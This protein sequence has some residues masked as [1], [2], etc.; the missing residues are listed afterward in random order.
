[1]S[2]KLPSLIILLCLHLTLFAQAPKS[3]AGK[4]ITAGLTA[5]VPIRVTG[6]HDIGAISLKLCFDE[7]LIA[8]TGISGSAFPNFQAGSDSGCVFIGWITDGISPAPTLP[9]GD[10]LLFV[11]FVFINPGTSPLVWTDNGI[12]CEFAGFPLIAPLSDTPTDQ[13]Y[14]DGWVSTLKVVFDRNYNTGALI[15]IPQDGQAPYTLSWT[16]PG[17]FSAGNTSTVY[18]PGNGYYT[19]HV[20]DALGAEGSFSYYYGPVHNTDTKLDY[21]SIQEAIDAPETLDGQH[22]LADPGVYLEMVSVY[23]SLRIQGSGAAQSRVS[24]ATNSIFTITADNVI[25]EDFEIS[26]SGIVSPGNNGLR[27]VQVQGAIIRNNLIKTN[28]CGIKLENADLNEITQNEILLN[29]H[30]GILL[31]GSSENEILDNVISGHSFAGIHLFANISSSALNTINDN[32]IHGNLNGILLEDDE[33]GAQL[34]GNVAGNQISNNLIYN[35][36]QSGLKMLQT[37]PLEIAQAELN[38]WGDATGPY[39]SEW[40][41]CGKGNAAIGN[42]DFDPWWWEDSR[43]HFN[44]LARPDYQSPEAIQSLPGVP[45]ILRDTLLFTDY[46]D[47]HPDILMDIALR[48]HSPA[49]P[50]GMRLIRLRSQLGN[51]PISDQALDYELSSDSVH[52]LSAITGIAAEALQTYANASLTLEFWMEGADNEMIEMPFLLETLTYSDPDSCISPA[53]NTD[54]ILLSFREMIAFDA[55]DRA[56]LLCDTFRMAFEEAFPVIR[57]SGAEILSDARIQ[58]ISP[59]PVPAGSRLD[60]STSFGNGSYD[61]LLPTSEIFLSEI[62]GMSSGNPLLN[63]SE[64]TRQWNFTLSGPDLFL[65]E[66]DLV[67]EG[68][69]QTPDSDYVY[70]SDTILLRNLPQVQLDPLSDIASVAGGPIRFL[71]AALYPTL[72]EIPTDIKADL[73]ITASQ[74]FPAGMQL[75]SIQRIL[76]GDTSDFILNYDLGTETEVSLCEIQG[77]DAPVM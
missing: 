50:T 8:F 62:L 24:S 11:D 28:Y 17:G 69:A 73:K 71:C 31:E 38:W 29:E 46:S 27:L 54:T 15:A 16:A 75:L 47:Y 56:Y 23:K 65:N 42:V 19:V 25:I 21:P 55:Q 7:N 45:F 64:V 67:L 77:M 6:F 57:H 59:F 1:M 41:P 48:C 53:G 3:F 63:E 20:T 51:G 2:K 76:P 61:I 37:P 35:N 72:D 66:Y 33:G 52:L 12:S 68:L 40:N 70:A 49:F 60:W 13:Y 9:D 4:E 26:H 22:I 36:T 10:T 5:S 58:I 30:S 32:E 43:V 44:G 74:A 18:P 14:F 39:H 34:T